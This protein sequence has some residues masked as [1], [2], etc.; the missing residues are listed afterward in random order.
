M[1]TEILNNDVFLGPYKHIAF[2]LNTEG[3]IE[4][5]FA[6]QVVS[7]YAPEFSNTGTRELGEVISVPVGDR[8]FHGIVCHSCVTEGGL[9]Q[10]APVAIQ[11]G[12]EKIETDEPIA[13]VLMGAG[14]VGRR[15]GADQAANVKAIHAA[16]KDVRLYSFEYNAQD[17]FEILNERIVDITEFCPLAGSEDRAVLVFSR[18]D[19]AMTIRIYCHSSWQVYDGTHI[20]LPIASL[21]F[22]A[23]D[24]VPEG[25]DVFGSRAKR[26]G[27]T[28]LELRT[29]IEENVPA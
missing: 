5:G 26:L 3:S 28:K 23:G 27:L 10:V 25:D 20:G 13:V 21:E 12:L 4:G 19:Q 18:I 14:E 11:Y 6:S 2:G 29:L 24:N 15:S 7:Q 1:I 16:K 17:I 9:W 8:V 22:E